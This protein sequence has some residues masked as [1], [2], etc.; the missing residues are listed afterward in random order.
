MYICCIIQKI[1][2]VY[3]YMLYNTY[4]SDS[5]YVYILYNTYKNDS[6][7]IYVV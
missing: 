1:V 5:I 3:V 4:N 6:I 2:T 7:C